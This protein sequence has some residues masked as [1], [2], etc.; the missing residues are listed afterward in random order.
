MTRPRIPWDD[1]Q[2]QESAPDYSPPVGKVRKLWGGQYERWTGLKWEAVSGQGM[3]R[4]RL[5]GT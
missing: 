5:V 2:P 4:A 3:D 1:P